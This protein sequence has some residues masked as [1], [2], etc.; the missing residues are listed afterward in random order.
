M[1]RVTFFAKD[2]Q[3]KVLYDFYDIHKEEDIPI[4][5]IIPDKSDYNRQGEIIGSGAKYF[6]DGSIYFP[7]LNYLQVKIGFKEL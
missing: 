4:N 7:H 3:T 6:P 2:P 5:T 1:S